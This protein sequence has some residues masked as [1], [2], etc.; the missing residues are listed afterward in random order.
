MAM[1]SSHRVS[2]RVWSTPVVVCSMIIMTHTASLLPT[3]ASQWMRRIVCP[4][5][6]MELFKASSVRVSPDSSR[7]WNGHYTLPVPWSFIQTIVICLLV[8]S[9]VLRLTAICS[10]WRFIC[11]HTHHQF[12]SILSFK[13]PFLLSK[14]W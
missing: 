3:D 9:I 8:R 6:N 1:Y 2:E 11:K 7:K 14:W 4:S 13:G 12:R 10:N 5:V